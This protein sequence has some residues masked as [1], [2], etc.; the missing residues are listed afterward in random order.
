[1]KNLRL[2]P[3]QQVAILNIVESAQQS[4]NLTLDS[5]P[6]TI[7]VR[8]AILNSVRTYVSGSSENE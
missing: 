4:G 8:C 6:T 1:M 5:N 7:F 3:E 2:T